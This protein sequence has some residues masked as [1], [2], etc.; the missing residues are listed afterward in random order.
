ME[1]LKIGSTGPNV[2]LLQSVLKKLGFYIA[3]IDG[4][5]GMSTQNAVKKFQLD[6]GITPDGIVGTTTWNALYPY[7]NGQTLYTV[8]SGD[9]LYSIAKNFNT[10]VNRILFANE[11]LDVNN[12][13]VG[14][15]LRVPFGRIV[16][17]N[18]SYSSNILK[19]NLT[20]LSNI[21]P[22]IQ[23]GII[24]NSSLNNTIPYIKIGTGTNEV[25]YSRKYSCK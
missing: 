7:I 20:A 18:I 23:V 19:M 24:G 25:F 10:S 1:I 9:T 4:I 5:F 2:E 16:P 14:L 17:T 13:P 15:V 22:F 12:L 8:K 21:Y 11:S 3:N 6:F